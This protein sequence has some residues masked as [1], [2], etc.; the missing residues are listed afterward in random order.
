MTEGKSGD[1]DKHFLVDLEGFVVVVVVVVVV[2]RF[3]VY[4]LC[5]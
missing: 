5:F 1:V 2:V 3:I 4:L